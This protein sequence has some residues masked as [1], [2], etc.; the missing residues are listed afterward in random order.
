MTQSSYT[1]LKGAANVD[2]T[3]PTRIL[4]YEHAKPSDEKPQM[5]GIMRYCAGSYYSVT[6]ANGI[7]PNYFNT[8]DSGLAPSSADQKTGLRLAIVIGE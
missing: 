7:T 3:D 8:G 2:L 5:E 1:A 6:L 4:S